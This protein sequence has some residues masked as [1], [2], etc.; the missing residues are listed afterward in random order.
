[1]IIHYNIVIQRQQGKSGDSLSL[2]STVSLSC[3]LVREI[4]RENAP[5]V[6]VKPASDKVDSTQPS[7]VYGEYSFWEFFIV[8]F[9]T[10]KFTTMDNNVKNYIDFQA[11]VTCDP[12]YIPSAIQHV[13][14]KSLRQIISEIEYT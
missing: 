7:A 5:F 1:M 6:F 14:S 13:E 9:N 4:T 8:R 12:D 3:Q 2:H 11:E 10:K